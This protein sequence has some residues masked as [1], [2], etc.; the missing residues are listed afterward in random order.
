MCSIGAGAIHQHLDAQ[1]VTREAPPPAVSSSLPENAQE[2]TP[3]QQDLPDLETIPH[4]IPYVPAATHPVEEI[5]YDVLSVH[6]DDLLLSGS[7]KA[8]LRN[9]TLWADTVSYNR[10]TGEILAQGHVRVIGG[11]NDE[12]LEASRGTYNLRTGTGRFYDVK[13]SVGMHTLEAAPVTGTAEAPSPFLFAGKMVVKSGPESYDVYEGWVT[14]CQLP[15]PDWL[16][17]A[18]HVWLSDRTAHARASTFRLLSVPVLFLPYVTHPV[19]ANQRQ[20]GVLIPVISQSSSKGFIFGDQVYLALGRSADA[21]AGFEYFSSR[22]FSEMGTLRFRGRG[23]DFL[24]AHFSAL[25]DR[26]FFQSIS[27][28]QVF[29]N[30]GGED[31][32]ASF[33]REFAPNLRAVGDAEYLS[34]YVYREAFNDNFN[35]AVSSDITS[36]AFLSYQPAGF[37]LSASVDRYQGLKRV[38]FY[39]GVVTKSGTPTVSYV[40]GEDIRLFH[41]PS[42]DVL[43][44]D[45][46]IGNTPLL[47]DISGS[48]AGLK[49]VQPNLARKDTVARADLRPEVSLPLSG[50]GWHTLTSMAVHATFYNKS[51]QVPY[52]AGAT[53]VIVDQPVTRTS[54]ELTSDI[55]PPAIERTFQVPE[56]LQHLFG[57]E[58]RHTIEPEIVYRNTS[59]VDNFLSLLRYDDVDLVANTNELEYG[60]TQHLYFRPKPHAAAKPRPGCPQVAPEAAATASEDTA[61]TVPAEENSTDANGIPSIPATAPDRP[62]HAHARRA[63]PCAAPTTAAQQE[64]LSWRLAQRH[65]FDQNFGGAVINGRRNVFDSTLSLSGIAF[66]TESRDISPLISRMR[67]RTSSHTD[68]GWDFDLDT[69]ASRFTSSNIYADLHEGQWFSGFSFAS[70][71][72]PGRFYTE[73]IDTSGLDSLTASPNSNFS[74]MRVLLGYG[75]PTKPGLSVATNAGFDLRNTSLQYASLQASYNWNCCG[76]SVEYRKYELGSVRNEGTERFSFTLINIGSAGN[77]RRQQR[78]F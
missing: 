14:S 42:I 58:V 18:R 22:G 2:S 17:S 67:F 36:R 27:N 59:G 77:L 50:D 71:N 8:T 21:T 9:R 23:N 75:A 43:S 54:F 63:G 51:R 29:V 73:T 33:R 30:Q 20:S 62:T 1:Q 5:E 12:S 66:L 40:P 48:L 32:T 38:P 28:Q 7:V 10:R 16:L 56:R 26:G 45:H 78:L 24:N 15:R 49:R 76:L 35:Q 37:D 64:W 6:G 70:L 65:F 13:G 68:L 31:V 74:Q 55:R 52:G 57:T 60:V 44:L 41:V 72:A 53:P 3:A 4:A 61:D 19:D 69:G 46:H 25:Q 34:S 39:R 11:D 47:W